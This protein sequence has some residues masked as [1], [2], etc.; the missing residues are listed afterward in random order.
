[1]A[2]RRNL[3][4]DEEDLWH[5]VARTIRPLHGKP[6]PS[7]RPPAPATAP[8]VSAPQPDPAALPRL[9]GFRLGEKAALRHPAPA[10]PP[11]R[12][13]A[14]THA[15]LT[16]GK[17]AP[18]ARI[19]L[20]GLTLAEA[21]AELVHFILNAQSDGLRL[22]LV[23]TGKGKPGTETG[24]LRAAGPIRQQVPHWLRLPPLGPAVQEV[25]E[26]HRRHGGAGACYVYLRRR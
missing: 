2:R 20:H 8:A 24:A 5:A 25:A 3:G 14:K 15:R 6:G 17:L 19:D 1:M 23:I 12:M 22:V 18:E 9:T 7:P 10:P 11:L 4:P 21:H 13:D 16:R 26:A